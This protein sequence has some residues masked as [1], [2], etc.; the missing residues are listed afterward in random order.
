MSGYK[1]GKYGNCFA[2]D[3][4]LGKQRKLIDTRDAQ[5][6]YVGSECY[7]LIKRAGE[8]GYQPPSGGPKLYLIK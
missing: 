7:K 5:T 2:C 6:A 1:V 3:K 8:L 4:T